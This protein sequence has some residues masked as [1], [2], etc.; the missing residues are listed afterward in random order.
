MN[1]VLSEEKLKSLGVSIT[2]IDLLKKQENFISVFSIGPLEIKNVIQSEFEMSIAA[3]NEAFNKAFGK[4]DEI[5]F[6]PTDET[7][8]AID[9]QIKE[10]L[11]WN[12][13]FGDY[14][15]EVSELKKIFKD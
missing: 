5:N 9:L 4:S 7:W 3:S 13:A 2:D 15:L 12:E 11:E 6:E 14:F 8:S 1:F 10:D